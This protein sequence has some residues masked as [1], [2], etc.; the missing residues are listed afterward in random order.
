MRAYQSSGRFS[1]RG[2]VNLTWVLAAGKVTKKARIP[3]GADAVVRLARQ[4][5]RF[6]RRKSSILQEWMR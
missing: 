6:S 1:G 3:A 2:N 4:F 5:A